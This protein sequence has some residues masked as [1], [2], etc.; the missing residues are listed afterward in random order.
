MRDFP[1][2]RWPSLPEPDALDERPPADDGERLA[3]IARDQVE[4]SWNG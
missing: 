3:R 1:A 4:R 2:D